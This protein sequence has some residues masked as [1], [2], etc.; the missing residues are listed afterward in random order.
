M[1]KLNIMTW[2]TQLYE[3]GNKIGNNKKPID[4]TKFMTI[5]NLVKEHLEKENSI[6]FLQEIPYCNNITW[7]E[8]ELFTEFK[9]IFQENYYDVVWNVE[10]K[11]Q[12]MMT[13]AIAKNGIINRDIDGYKDNRCVSVT[14]KYNLSDIKIMGIHA[15]NMSKTKGH[16]N[17]IKKKF[18]SYYNIILGDFN[19]GNYLKNNESSIFK[20][21]RE[22][23]LAFAEG[24]I[25]VCQG[26]ATTQY[27]TPI[28]HILIKNTNRRLN[29]PF[30]IFNE[31]N[32]S[33]HFPIT[34][35]IKLYNT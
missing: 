20:E 17:K 25:D 32:S 9:D 11:K 4:K 23:Y 14:V 15:K 18:P 31:I 13:V 27:S 10:S 12:I 16:L 33:D 21:N 29:Y 22:S 26:Q 1:D 5:I 24:Y 30:K 28:D 3:Q 35:D 6:A 19:A 34:C 8:H 2:N 7:N